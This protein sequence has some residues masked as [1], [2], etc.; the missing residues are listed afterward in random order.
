MNSQHENTKRA[1]LDPNRNNSI[2]SSSVSSSYVG[3]VTA[4]SVELVA[5]ASSI[6]RCVCSYLC[7]IRLIGSG[8]EGPSARE[9]EGYSWELNAPVL[10]STVENNS[11]DKECSSTA[12]TVENNSDVTE[13]SS[14]DS[15]VENNSDDKECSSTALN[16]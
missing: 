9:I 15:T 2:R 11:D 10:P 5:S 12:S 14:T 4:G 13:C 7:G 8:S 6:P 3:L 1:G 16:C